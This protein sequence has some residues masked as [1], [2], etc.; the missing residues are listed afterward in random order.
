MADCRIKRVVIPGGAQKK[1]HAPGK[2]LRVQ[3][4]LFIKPLAARFSGTKTVHRKPLPSSLR[5]IYISHREILRTYLQTTQ[6]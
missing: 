1:G 2:S 3:T 5:F 6:Y 4:R